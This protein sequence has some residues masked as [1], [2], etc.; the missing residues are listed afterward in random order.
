MMPRFTPV[1]IVVS[2]IGQPAVYAQLNPECRA[3]DSPFL[4]YEDAGQLEAGM[5]SSGQYASFAL[6]AAGDSLSVPGVDFWSGLNGRLELWGSGAAGGW[7]GDGEGFRVRA[8]DSYLGM[9]V[10]LVNVAHAYPAAAVRPGLDLLG[11]GNGVRRPHAVL[12]LILRK[13]VKL[14]NLALTA[15]TCHTIKGRRG[16]IP[17][18][19]LTSSSCSS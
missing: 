13:D 16:C 18:Q 3:I 9:K 7:Q 12:P 14:C 8:E 10:L 17:R 2:F 4:T 5:L 1:L 19:F 15:S 6:A 11:S